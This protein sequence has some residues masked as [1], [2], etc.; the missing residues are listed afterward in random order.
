MQF[1]T[2]KQKVDQCD[3]FKDKK[4]VELYEKASKEK[5]QLKY[6]HHRF[7]GQCFQINKTVTEY[8]YLLRIFELK[9]KFRTVMKK[10]SK[11]QEMKKNV[12][13]CIIEKFRG[14]DIVSIEYGRRQQIKFLPIDIIYKPVKKWDDI[15]NFYFSTDLATAYRAEWSTGKSLRNAQ[16]Y[17]CYYI[18]TPVFIYIVT[19]TV[20]HP[21]SKVLKTYRKIFRNSWSCI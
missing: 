15:I 16:V 17:Q 2:K 5:L 1:V 21:K 9:K 19:L 8:G 13:S 10:D 6:N 7:E 12:S 4:G 3:N 18:V 14:F 11:K 20:L